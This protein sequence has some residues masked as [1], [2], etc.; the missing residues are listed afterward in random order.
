MH[1]SSESTYVQW[2]HLILP[3]QKHPSRAELPQFRDDAGPRHWP[4]A[5][6]GLIRELG[7]AARNGAVGKPVIHPSH[8]TVVNAYHAVPAATYLDA[9]KILDH[10]AGGGVIRS[11][12]GDK[13]NE[14][15]PHSRP[16]QRTAQQ[17]QIFGVLR[18]GVTHVDVLKATDPHWRVQLQ[19]VGVRAVV[20]TARSVWHVVTGPKT[21][22]TQPAT[23]NQQPT[24]TRRM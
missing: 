3:T 22:N 5:F 13:M 4:P 6:K 10:A 16:S 15:K 23:G 18:P 2:R 12:A 24:K 7:I 19:P 1:T 17:A 8:V 20:T 11:D 21:R 9:Q 14:V